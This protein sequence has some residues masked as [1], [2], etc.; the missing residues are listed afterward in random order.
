MPRLYWLYKKKPTGGVNDVV[1]TGFFRFLFFFF[2]S[3]ATERR[4]WI[5]S[6][7][8]CCGGRKSRFPPP[9]YL[10]LFFSRLKY[11]TDAPRRSPSSCLLLLLPWREKDE[12]KKDWLT[13]FR[14]CCSLPRCLER[15]HK[16]LLC[17][18]INVS[19]ACVHS[20]VF[21]RPPRETIGIEWYLHHHHNNHHR[22]ILAHTHASVLP[23]NKTQ[24]KSSEF[25]NLSFGL[26][27]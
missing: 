24:Q 26:G 27:L 6:C 11:T 20:F 10:F 7:G 2:P 25:M 16:R 23:V 21:D 14:L 19:P 12:G 8:G 15:E 22:S 13:A 3:Y 9:P 1:R 5:W 18:D 4:S 17:V